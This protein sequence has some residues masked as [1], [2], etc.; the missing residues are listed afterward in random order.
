LVPMVPQTTP[1][2]P[3]LAAALRATSGRPSAAQ[4][5]F[6]S[7]TPPPPTYTLSLHDALPICCADA[8][9]HHQCCEHRAKLAT[10]RDRYHRELGPDRKSTRLNSSHVSSSYAVLCVKKQDTASSGPA[11]R[12]RPPRGVRRPAVRRGGPPR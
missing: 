2:R 4:L 11:R 12:G 1:P 3:T 6:F 5:P 9:R 8:T 10:D 7:A